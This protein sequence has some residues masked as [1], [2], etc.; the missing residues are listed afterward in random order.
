VAAL[1]KL[2]PQLSPR[3]QP[4]LDIL[5]RHVRQIDL[6]ERELPQ[7]VWQLTSRADRLGLDDAYR[8]LYDR[9]QRRATTYRVFLLLATLALLA[10]A[11]LAFI[12]LRGQAS[13]LKLAASVFATAAEGITITDTRGTILDV[14][15][16]FTA[17]TG[18]TRQEALGKIR[19]CCSQG[20]TTPRSTPACGGR[21]VSMGNGR[22]KSGI[23]AK[24]V[25]STPSGSP[26]PPA[27]RRS[28]RARR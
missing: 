4:Q 28:A 17:L 23:G 6:F 25:R 20:G 16:A 12:R 15:A 10:Y 21:S 19:A 24:A 3:A 2:R 7:L 14:N 8:E 9:Q 5:L 1:Q 11:V 27:R 18:Y 26:S 22:A 13:R